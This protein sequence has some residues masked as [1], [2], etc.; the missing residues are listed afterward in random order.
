[1]DF[2]LAIPIKRAPD[3]VFRFLADIQ[4]YGDHRPGSRVPVMD[5]VTPG[6]TRVGT[7]WHEVVRLAPR[8]HMTVWSW[9]TEYEPPRRM[10]ESFR[11]SW[12]RGWI[13][14]RVEPTEAGAILHHRESLIPRGPL[15]W[16]DRPIARMLRPNLVARLQSIRGLLEGGAVVP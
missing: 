12:M 2:D 14:Y 3:E 1:M 10:L 8:L 13:E 7:R 6:P 16:L 15:R 5:K 9:V 4:R 11:S